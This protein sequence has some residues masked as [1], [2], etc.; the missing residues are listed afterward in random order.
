MKNFLDQKCSIS[1]CNLRNL[2]DLKDTATNAKH[3][4]FFYLSLIDGGR[5]GEH[6]ALTWSD[7]DFEHRKLTISKGA[8]EENKTT[9]AKSTKSKKTRVV[10][11]DDIA[12][13]LFKKHKE[14]QDKWLQKNKLT[15]PNQYVFLK[16][17]IKKVEM[18][19]HSMFWHWLESFLKKN[20]L[21]HIG[22]HGFRRM[23]A[24]YAAKAN[25]P[26]T[27]I[28]AM[29]GHADISTTNRYLRYLTKDRIESTQKMSGIFH[30][31][32]KKSE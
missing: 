31:M 3:K 14:Y 13:D 4:L 23:A 19:T 25:V 18:P 22:V 8:Y 17:R 15:N 30:S 7:I 1:T 28:Q 10:Y 9:K 12:E 11:F 32:I 29:L 24:T 5:L 27:T 21:M 6:I 20:D 16:T 2:F 26:L